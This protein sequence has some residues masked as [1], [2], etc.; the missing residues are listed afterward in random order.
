ME[1]VYIWVFFSF[2]QP[3]AVV[4]RGL[5]RLAELGSGTQI[6]YLAD[7]VELA[8]RAQTVAIGGVEITVL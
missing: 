2:R 4:D 1:A 6:V 5:R 3:Q 7:D 8:E